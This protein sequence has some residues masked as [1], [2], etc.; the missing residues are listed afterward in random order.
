MFT[1][2]E[3]WI[4]YWEKCKKGKVYKK[5]KKKSSLPLLTFSREMG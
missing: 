4:T 5:R 1:K 2:D 3:K